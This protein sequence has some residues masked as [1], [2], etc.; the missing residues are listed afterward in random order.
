MRRE[1]F[2]AGKQED[3]DAEH[4]LAIPGRRKITRIDNDF[5]DVLMPDHA[6][7][8]AGTAKAFSASGD[9]RP[10]ITDP[11]SLNHPTA[12]TRDT[13]SRSSSSERSISGGRTGPADLFTAR[14]PALTI[15]TA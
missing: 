2:V 9:S 15:D 4:R 11:T 10:V 5:S 8:T 13:T 1:H 3:A 14:I 6:Y 12:C 7:Q